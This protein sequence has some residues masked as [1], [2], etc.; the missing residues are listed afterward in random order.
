MLKGPILRCLLLALLWSTSVAG[1][2]LRTIALDARA[3][4]DHG[5]AIDDTVWLGSQADATTQPVIIGALTAR[6]ADPAE[7]A[8]ADYRARLHL[9]Q[10]QELLA[11]GD[12]VDRFAVAAPLGAIT[13]TA[14]ARINAAAFGFRAHRTAD[15]AVETS[16]TFAVLSR[17]QR[18]I[19]VITIVASA[20][21]LLCIMLL[22]VEERRRDVA[23]LR[24]MGI[25]RRT[26]MGAV[27]LEA[28]AIALV[29]SGLGAVL[30]MII[31]L[32][33]NQHYQAVYRTPL[34]FSL[35]TPSTVLLAV[36]LSAVIGIAAGF[37]A[38]ARLVRARPLTLL[39]R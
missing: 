24:L 30:G 22:K 37:F 32:I 36:A 4:A 18:A 31:S 29:G 21:F 1:Q 26:V 28:T 3:A 25:S 10:L 7:V 15:V 11:Y 6:S 5:V 23:A 19:G 35:V 13:D 16:A 20:T 38:S 17:F 2:G 9:T 34:V 39:G 12:R 8:R 14:V 27:V 33:V